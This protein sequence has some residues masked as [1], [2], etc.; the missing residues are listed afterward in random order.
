VRLPPSFSEEEGSQNL[1][2]SFSKITNLNGI[3]HDETLWEN[4]STL[5]VRDGVDE[6]GVTQHVS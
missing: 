1:K 5:R 4:S 3:F 2:T 6:P